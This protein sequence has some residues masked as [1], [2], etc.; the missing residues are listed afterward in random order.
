[1]SNSN[2]RSLHSA[3]LTPSGD[4]FWNLS[5]YCKAPQASTAFNHRLLATSSLRSIFANVEAS[6]VMRALGSVVLSSCNRESR[7]C[8]FVSPTGV[9][10]QKDDVEI[11]DC[12]TVL[13]TG[14]PMFGGSYCTT[15]DTRLDHNPL[16][17]ILISDLCMFATSAQQRKCLPRTK[18]FRER[19]SQRREDNE[20]NPCCSLGSITQLCGI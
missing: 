19:T 16:V 15:H 11:V 2:S 7:I 5:W 9:L 14:Q 10:D 4:L 17:Y 12:D 8:V 20:N 18:T 6:M 3:A 1:M 13:S